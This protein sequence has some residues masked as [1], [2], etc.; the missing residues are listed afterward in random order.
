MYTGMYVGELYTK[1]LNIITF[2]VSLKGFVIY[3][4]M[5]CMDNAQASYA[6]CFVVNSVL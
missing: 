6:T 1:R 4:F 5:H 2:L 3:V